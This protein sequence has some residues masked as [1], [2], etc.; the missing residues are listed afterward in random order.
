MYQSD[1]EESVV[2][3]NQKLHLFKPLPSIDYIPKSDFIWIHFLINN[4]TDSELNYLWNIPYDYVEVRINGG[5]SDQVFK[6]GLQV[7]LKDKAHQIPW[8]YWAC[9]VPINLPPQSSIS[10]LTRANNVTKSTI[11]PPNLLLEEVSSVDQAHS[12]QRLFKSTR[13]GVY[14]TL[15]CLSLIFSLVYYG[16]T[17]RTYALYFGIMCVFLS[18]ILLSINDFI[19]LIFPN[20]PSSRNLIFL[21]ISAG[22]HLSAF[23][24]AQKFVDMPK[25]FP[26]LYKAFLRYYLTYAVAVSC[27]V[28]YTMITGE[29]G[30][31]LILMNIANSVVY[32]L[33]LVIAYALLKKPS[34]INILYGSASIYSTVLGFLSIFYLFQGYRYRSFL[35]NEIHIFGFVIILIIGLVILTIRDQMNTHGELKEIQE[36]LNADTVIV[37]TNSE[38]PAGN[39]IIDRIEQVILRNLDNPQFSVEF[40]A[41]ELEVSARTIGRHVKKATGKTTIEW[42]VSQRL[43]KAKALLEQKI[44]NTPHQVSKKVGYTNYSYFSKVYQEQYGKS[45]D[46]YYA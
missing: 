5:A 12:A 34:Y 31:S 17:R 4:E 27:V 7:P 44:Y 13:N 19:Y 9:Y 41:E 18:L 10:V 21:I 45:P 29:Y 39:Q 1:T 3:I 26:K 24:F 35:I 20:Y 6:T 33:G 40:L 38:S 11:D 25:Q 30:Y 46:S 36:M 28:L 37:S 16:I 14:Q 2:E 23:W 15:L 43:S 42:I 22:I 8:S 32:I